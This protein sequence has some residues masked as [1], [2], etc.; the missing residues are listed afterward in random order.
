MPG[1]WIKKLIRLPLGCIPSG[2]VLPVLTG[3]MRGLR[4]TVGAGT[5]G[6]WLGTYE[7]DK[8]RDFQRLC[9]PGMCVYDIGANVGY[10]TLLAS[11]TTGPAGRVFAFEPFP[12]NI[13]KIEQHL[14]LNKVRN[15][16][17]VPAAVSST[18]GTARF[19]TGM[20][21]EM[22][23]LSNEG[24][25]TVRTLSIDQGIARGEWPVPDVMKIDVEGA[26]SEVLTGAA[27][28]LAHHHPVIVLACH[29]TPQF[30]ACSDLLAHA[31][32]QLESKQ[33]EPGMYDVLATRPNL[34][35]EPSE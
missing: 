14:S 4:W 6:Y 16:T 8:Q 23:R 26:E 34:Q 30:R 22:G 17:I 3:P 2:T 9:Q 19:Q 29:G 1:A 13:E 33:Y 25:L 21:N 31:G 18:D 27:Q 20:A 28:L 10:Y 32:Y 7:R 11:H 5:H 35:N 24:D 12:N 15:V